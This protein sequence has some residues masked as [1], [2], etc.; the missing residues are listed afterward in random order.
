MRNVSWR[1]VLVVCALGALVAGCGKNNAATEPQA[2]AGTSTPGLTAQPSSVTIGVGTSTSVSISGGKPP[3]S[4]AV[5]PDA[6]A[7]AQLVNA[8]SAVA[9]LQI[10][11]VSVASPSTAVTIQDNSA[12]PPL[13]VAVPIKVQ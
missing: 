1:V 4:I 10:S 8:D 6:R 7:T 2:P 9:T 13:T 5:S 12:A 11:G 3:Y